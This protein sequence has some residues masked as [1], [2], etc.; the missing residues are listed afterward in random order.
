MD[1][2]EEICASADPQSTHDFQLSQQLHDL[3][4]VREVLSDLPLTLSPEVMVPLSPVGFVMG[5]LKHTNEVG[6]T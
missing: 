4:T 5:T 2:P 1:F 6:R 3:T